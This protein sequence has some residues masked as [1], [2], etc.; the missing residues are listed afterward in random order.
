VLVGDEATRGKGICYQMVKEILKI[1]FAELGL[2]RITL[3]AYD[4]NKSAL[5]CY[6]KAGFVVEGIH[7]DILLYEGRYWSMVEMAILE[8]EWRALQNS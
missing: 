4:T 5:K 3:G 1:G 7:R 8:E 2:H 6:E